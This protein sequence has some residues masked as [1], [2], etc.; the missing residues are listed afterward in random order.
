MTLPL[1]T[2][3]TSLTL[4]NQDFRAVGNPLSHAHGGTDGALI[5]LASARD[6]DG[7]R[8]LTSLSIIGSPDLTSEGLAG[9]LSTGRCGSSLITLELAGCP[10]M[11]E[12]SID[13]IA[14]WTPNLRELTLRGQLPGA[15]CMGGEEISRASLANL[16]RLCP[17]LNSLSLNKFPLM[18]TKAGDASILKP[19]AELKHLVKVELTSLH[20]ITADDLAHF[21]NVAS[22]RIGHLTA[23]STIP[24]LPNVRSFTWTGSAVGA[25]S[26]ESLFLLCHRSPYLRRLV[27][28]WTD[29]WPPFSSSPSH[30]SWDAAHCASAECLPASFA[31]Y[32]QLAV[33]DSRVPSELVARA[34]TEAKFLESVAV[35]GYGQG[36]RLGWR[37]VKTME[38][39][40]PFLLHVD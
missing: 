11:L 31:D 22:L 35:F 7:A 23:L 36:K 40:L 33:F 6:A 32:A 28:D 18:A 34:L 12:S 25:L 20:F 17:M 13:D 9:Y 37:D 4:I 27:L 38:R 1:F 16:A 14:E 15:M 10:G 21:G 3:L 5:A 24:P 8:G 30:A 39:A 19:F 26:L 2:S 29:H